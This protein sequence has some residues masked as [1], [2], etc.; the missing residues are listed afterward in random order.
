MSNSGP[1]GP[2]ALGIGELAERSGKRPSLIRYYEQIGLLP[3][4]VRIGGQRRYD[5]GTLRMLAVIDVAQRAGLSLAEIGTLLGASPDDPAAVERL[6]D[7]AV[8]KLPEVLALIERTELVRGW[9]E[10][11]AR[12][13]CPA[14]GDCALFDDPPLPAAPRA[15]PAHRGRGAPGR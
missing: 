8:R 11:A 9:L 2:P 5:Q 13:E 14:L 15:G 10:A 4:P 7:L 6:R 12:C 3:E 1:D